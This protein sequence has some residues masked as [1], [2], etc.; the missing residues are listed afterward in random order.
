MKGSSDFI[1]QNKT[2]SNDKYQI[3]FDITEREF[4]GRII[5]DYEYVEV[6]EVS[7]NKIIEAIIEN[8]YS[9]DAEIAMINNEILHSG[10]KEYITYQELR[11]KAKQ[12]ADSI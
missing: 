3:Y 1:P 12:I 10:D 9:K 2:F 4:E 7:R 11:A 8:T 5:Y 6:S